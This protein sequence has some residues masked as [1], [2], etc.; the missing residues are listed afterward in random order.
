MRL[1]AFVAVLALAACATTTGPVGLAGT[2]WQLVKFQGSDGKTL[3]PD[4]PARYTVEFFA[5]GSVAMRID[6]NRGRGTW[7]SA[8]PSQLEFG[9]MA[10]TRVA[11]PPG[12]LENRFGRDIGNVRSYVVRNQRLFLALMADGGIYEFEPRKP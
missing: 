5:D 11:C 4:D 9:P 1:A 7:K 6:C 3:T 2:A 10:V 12:T 8:G